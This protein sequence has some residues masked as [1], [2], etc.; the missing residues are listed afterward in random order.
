MRTDISHLPLR[1][2]KE[3]ERIVKAIFEEFE[4]EHKLAQGDRKLGRILKILLYGS[5]A[6][7]DWVYAPEAKNDYRSDYDILIIV[8]QG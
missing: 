4:D 7:N 3:L 6:R 8:N 2:Q 1:N 5:F